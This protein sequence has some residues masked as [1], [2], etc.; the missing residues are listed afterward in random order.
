MH[1]IQYAK[2]SFS[3]PNFLEASASVIPSQYA[4]SSRVESSGSN[5]PPG[6]TYILPKVDLLL[7]LTINISN[8]PSDASRIKIT[9]AAGLMIVDIAFV[10]SME[11]YYPLEYS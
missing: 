8:P 6:K 2:P 9:V 11:F 1:A 3:I 5:L 4:Y 10:D 7:R